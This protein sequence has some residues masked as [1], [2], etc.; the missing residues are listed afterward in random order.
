MSDTTARCMPRGR[1]RAMSVY[2]CRETSRPGG[3]RVNQY[4]NPKTIS[5]ALENFQSWKTV[6]FFAIFSSFVFF[7]MHHE[8]FTSV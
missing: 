1:N 4:P 3:C 2:E 7:V 5:C 6:N 8:D